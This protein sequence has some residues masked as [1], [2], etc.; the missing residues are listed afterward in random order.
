[1]SDRPAPKLPPKLKA[2]LVRLVS[3]TR[4]SVTQAVKLP[5][6][7]DVIAMRHLGRRITEASHEAWNYGVVAAEAWRHLDRCGAGGDFQLRVIPRSEEK[8]VELARSSTEMAL[9]L[10]EEEID[11]VDFVVSEYAEMGA[12]E[13]G[14]LTKA[15]NPRI[16]QW[17]KNAQ[18][19]L[20]IEAYDALT[21]QARRLARAIRSLKAED[22][23]DAEAV[24]LE[25][26]VA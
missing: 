5:Y 14:A 3:S 21:P 16:T 18:V 24:T 2:V 4:L 13:L 9:D 23:Q 6:L 17:G 20:G 26:A 1:M 11:I 15:M 22:F 25:D 8:R 19:D 12:V 10:A 7:V